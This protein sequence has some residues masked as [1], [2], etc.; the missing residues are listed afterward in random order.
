MKNARVLFVACL[1]STAPLAGNVCNNCPDEVSHT[2]MFTRPLTQMLG[3]QQAL[4]YNY[5]F[6]KKHKQGVAFQVTALYQKSLTLRENANYFLLPCNRDL[7]VSG[8]DNLNDAATRDIR[9]EWLNLPSNFRGQFT[10][11]P[12]Q[13]QMGIIIEGNKALDAYF[14]HPSFAGT[15]VDVI[16]PITRVENNLKITQSNVVD[17]GTNCP[18]DIIDAFK[19]HEWLYAKMDGCCRHTGFPDFT[20]LVG[21]TFLAE[22]DFLVAY[23]TKFVMP[24]S[25]VQNPAF[26]FSPVVGNNNHFGYGGGACFQLVLNRDVIKT[27][28]CLFINFESVFQARND[29]KRTFDLKH[30][31]FSRYLKLVDKKA[32]VGS[33]QP[34][35]NILTRECD[36]HPYGIFDFSSGLRF[37]TRHSEWEFGYSIWA[38][39]REKIKLHCRFPEDR[40]GIAGN[41]DPSLIPNPAG[42]PVT[43][44]KST[45]AMQAE[46]DTIFPCP[47]SCDKELH[48]VALRES[49]LD[50]ESGAAKAA[51]NHKIH[52]S[53][54]YIYTGSYMDGFVGMGLYY[55]LPMKNSALNLFGGWAKAGATF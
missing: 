29:Q 38:H 34:G 27:H 15:W 50:L 35:V 54:G 26:I 44:S 11:N 40:Y 8:D 6:T 17:E 36:V 1:I 31:P 14:D 55:D 23:Y 16:I 51:F 2:F 48:F 39:A 47:A 20:L 45:I 19:Q 3:V 12:S 24:T 7:L 18:H 5:M 9:A 21:R 42:I 53:W 4:W 10:V 43:A 13:K 32:P 37:K 28:F 46:N 22:D 52:V 33:T 30:K 41:N 25:N 49:D